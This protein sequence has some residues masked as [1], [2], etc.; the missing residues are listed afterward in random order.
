MTI[1][2]KTH[3]EFY[4]AIKRLTENGLGFDAYVENLEIRL[5]GAY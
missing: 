5:T 3:L 4:D 2:C 1:H